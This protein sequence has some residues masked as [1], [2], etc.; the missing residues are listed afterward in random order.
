MYLCTISSTIFVPNIFNIFNFFIQYGSFITK[1]LNNDTISKYK[2]SYI[3]KYITGGFI[4]IELNT[5]KITISMLISMDIMTI[6]YL[7]G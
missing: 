5:K 7:L 4:E 2:G 1:L 3:E 6:I